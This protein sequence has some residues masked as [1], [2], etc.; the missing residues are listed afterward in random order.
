[1]QKDTVLIK[2][3]SFNIHLCKTYLQCISGFF[4]VCL[5]CSVQELYVVCRSLSAAL[6]EVEAMKKWL[7][8]NSCSL[9]LSLFNEIPDLLSDVKQF[10]EALNEAAVKLVILNNMNMFYRQHLTVPVLIVC[11]YMYVTIKNL[12]YCLKDV[13]VNNLYSKRV[14]VVQLA[15]PHKLY[16]THILSLHQRNLTGNFIFF[17]ELMIRPIFSLMRTISQTLK[18]ERIRLRLLG[19]KSQIIDGKLESRFVSRLWIMSQ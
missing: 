13:L 9:L 18:K 16:Q 11:I 10:K 12:F 5:Q 8:E 2:E 17:I 15:I 7:T 3:K 1:M 4:S 6:C 14:L 19:E